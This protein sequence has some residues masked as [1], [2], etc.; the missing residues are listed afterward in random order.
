MSAKT[1]LDVISAAEPL[2]N[3]TTAAARA[4]LA[5][6]TLTGIQACLFLTY[7]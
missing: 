4:I 7:K 6:T 5:P 3:T 1:L 2:T